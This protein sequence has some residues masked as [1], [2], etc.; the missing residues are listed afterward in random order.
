MLVKQV[1]NRDV[2]TTIDSGET[3]LSNERETPNVTQ[4]TK[5]DGL[6][7]C[8]GRGLRGQPYRRRAL[9]NLA[10]NLAGHNQGTQ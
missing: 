7:T 1:C 5:T 10:Q 8:R 3:Y 9:L 4:A 2:G 6:G